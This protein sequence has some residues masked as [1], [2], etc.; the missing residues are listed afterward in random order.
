SLQL[1]EQELSDFLE[2][3]VEG[4]QRIGRDGRI[5][6][7]NRALLDLLGYTPEEY[8]GRRVVEFHADPAVLEEHWERLMRGEILYDCP[9]RLRR[10]DGSIRHVLIHS[11]G[12][13]E[14]GRF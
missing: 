12:F 6:W 8:V 3:A 14:D 11:N 9:A 10:K 7:A 1:R 4:L 5:L 13:W 2:N